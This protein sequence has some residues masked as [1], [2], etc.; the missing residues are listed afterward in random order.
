MLIVSIS[1]GLANQMYEYMSAYALAKELNQE[2]VLDISECANSAY[3]YLLDYFKIPDSRKLIYSQVSVAAESHLNC[4]SALQ[5]FDNHTVVLVDGIKTKERYASESRVLVYTGLDMAGELR[6]YENIYMC[7]YFMNRDLYYEKYWNEVSHFFV[8]KEESEEVRKFKE[9]IAGQISVGVHIRRGDMLLADW[10]VK[11]EDDYYRAAIQSCRKILGDCI[12]CIF[13]D[14][15]QYA[16]EILGKDDSIHYIHFDGYNDAAVNEFVCLSLCNH[17][18]LSNSSTFSLL[19]DALNGKKERHVFMKYTGQYKKYKKYKK[20]TPLWLRSLKSTIYLT[21]KDIKKYSKNY[22]AVE[23]NDIVTE[24]ELCD[25]FLRLSGENRYQEALQLAFCIYVQNKDNE[26][27][28]L[29]LSEVLMKAGFYEESVVELAKRNIQG[30]DRISQTSIMDEKTKCDMQVLYDRLTKIYDK[31]FIIVLYEPS[32]PAGRTYGLIDLGILLMHLGHK[33]TFIYEPLFESDRYY[34]E[35]SRTLY[36]ALGIDM[37][38]FHY[39][40]EEVLNKGVAEF[41]EQFEDEELYVISRDSRFFKGKSSV[42]EIVFIATDTSDEYD[43]EIS[44]YAV[45]ESNLEILFKE[46]DIILT[47]NHEFSDKEEYVYW[48]PRGDINERL[49][50]VSTQW[51]YGYHQRLNRRMI[52][53]AEAL[54]ERLGK[55]WEKG[56]CRDGKDSLG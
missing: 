8:L 12:F 13:S 19:A 2:L 1:P 25:R 42:K 49:K 45:N 22:Y 44:T 41:Y 40:K 28:I 36:N 43:V 24:K 55:D 56:I 9:L 34:L 29:S 50:F 11:L 35:K 39:S 7:G 52:G 26:E 38:C 20:Y 31:H 18:V 4:D 54:C 30:K 51:L 10:A 6:K 21:E 53:M 23:F 37:G 17:R 48:Q 33:V 15:I 5:L 47:T 3:G 16:K 46:A 27:F 32:M 14:D